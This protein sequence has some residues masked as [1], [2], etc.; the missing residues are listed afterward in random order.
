MKRWQVSKEAKLLFLR[1]GSFLWLNLAFSKGTERQRRSRKKRRIAKSKWD[2]TRKY[3]AFP[4]SLCDQCYKNMLLELDS[5]FHEVFSL[6][7]TA[8]NARRASCEQILEVNF[9][10]AR[11]MQQNMKL[12]HASLR[13]HCTLL[14]SSVWA[15]SEDV[16]K[17]CG[18]LCFFGDKKWLSYLHT[19]RCHYLQFSTVEL[20]ESCHFTSSSLL[21]YTSDILAH[22][23]YGTTYRAGTASYSFPFALL[24]QHSSHP[25]HPSRNFLFRIG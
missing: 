24:H 15:L 19:V 23:T 4:G 12:L 20:I 2:P 11:K 13:C 9:F 10:A 16:S 17:V 6:E 3:I 1:V 22:C 18:L 14:F 7:L 5:V 8:Q 21:L 25:L